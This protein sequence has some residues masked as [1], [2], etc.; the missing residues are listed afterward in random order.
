MQMSWA[1]FNQTENMPQ[2]GLKNSL[3]VAFLECVHA[4]ET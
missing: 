2:H 1:L 4:R 3:L